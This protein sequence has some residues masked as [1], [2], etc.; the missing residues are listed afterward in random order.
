MTLS[1][2]NLCYII[3]FD[4][5]RVCYSVDVGVLGDRGRPTACLR[6]TP[7]HTSALLRYART[8]PNKVYTS[9]KSFD[10]AEWPITQGY[11]SIVLV[12]EF[13]FCLIFLKFDVSHRRSAY[14]FSCLSLPFFGILLCLSLPFFGIFSCLSS[15]FWVFLTSLFT[16]L[17]IFYV[18]HYCTGYCLCL[19]SPFW[20]FLMSLFT[21][22]GIF[23]VS[24]YCTGYCW[25][26]SLPFWL[27]WCLSLPFC[28]LCTFL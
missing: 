5:V 27:F 2:K 25:C 8:F 21:V 11:Q 16:V 19:S 4:Q 26:L 13:D 3:W 17:G 10:P 20:V 14:F 9:F 23:Y 24:H 28:V 1:F 15:P 12:S 18:S 7:R 6:P 22:F